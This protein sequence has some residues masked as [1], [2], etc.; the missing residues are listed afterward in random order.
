MKSSSIAS[1]AEYGGRYVL[2]MLLEYHIDPKIVIF[3]VP[4]FSQIIWFQA[5]SQQSFHKVSTIVISAG[6]SSDWC[7]HYF[8]TED[9]V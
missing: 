6:L 4:A 8:L 3:K 1:C 2:T 5:V 7:L 9:A